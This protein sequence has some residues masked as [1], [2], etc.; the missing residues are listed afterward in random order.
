MAKLKK[1]HKNFLLKFIKNSVALFDTKT[2]IEMNDQLSAWALK[3][4][5]SLT[6]G[7]S[8]PCNFTTWNTENLFL[9]NPK[10]MRRLKEILIVAVDHYTEEL[11]EQYRC[12]KPNYCTGWVN[13]MSRFDGLVPPHRHHSNAFNL[14][15]VYYAA[16]DYTPIRGGTRFWN[17][18]TEKAF[19]TITP[20]I[21]ELVIFPATMLHAIVRYRQPKPR[22]TFGFD[23]RF[24][25]EDLY[26]HPCDVLN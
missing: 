19:L 26:N 17:N 6:E 20:K 24:R 10:E 7:S 9:T 2:S 16:G 22:I 5:A 14:A 15:A 11:Q 12:K 21:G 8:K 4:H 13:I 25:K 18:A 23:I 3:K 1:Q